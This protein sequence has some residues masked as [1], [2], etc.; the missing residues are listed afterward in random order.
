MSLISIS[1]TELILSNLSQHNLFFVRADRAAAADKIMV[2]FSILFAL[3]ILSGAL[4]TESTSTV[5]RPYQAKE[6]CLIKYQVC[7]T[8]YCAC[9]YDY[10]NYHKSPKYC[11]KVFCSEFKYKHIEEKEKDHA[12]IYLKKDDYDHTKGSYGE[13]KN[14]YD[15]NKG[16]YGHMKDNYGY[17][18]GRVRL[19]EG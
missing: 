9:G 12:E 11:E 19:Q 1:C 17:K 18:K 6:K 4:L 5:A 8:K 7:C 2:K 3:T 15:Y 14:E 13:K 16:D 10:N